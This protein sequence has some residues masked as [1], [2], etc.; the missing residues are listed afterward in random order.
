MFYRISAELA[1]CEMPPYIPFHWIEFIFR[2]LKFNYNKLGGMAR[3]ADFFKAPAEGFSLCLRP[4][5]SDSFF[6]RQVAVICSNFRLS[7]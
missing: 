5:S 1:D 6:I 2:H 7:F 3:H 4:L